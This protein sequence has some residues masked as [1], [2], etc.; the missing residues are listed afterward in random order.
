MTFKKTMQVCTHMHAFL[1]GLEIT[2]KYPLEET[3]ELF[4]TVL[5]TVKG[6]IST[7]AEMSEVSNSTVYKWIREDEEFARRVEDIQAVSK[8]TRLDKAEDVLDTELEY[9]ENPFQVAKYVLDNQ[10]QNRGFGKG[11]TVNVLTQVG[12]MGN[13]PNDPQ[14]PEEWSHVVEVEKKQLA[15][16][17]D[18]D[19]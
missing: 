11:R 14:T 12:I 9:G 3:R 17:K 10:G 2:M 1:E 6:R 7:A 13:Y 19:D 5:P 16:G 18:K 15:E 4:L 8:E